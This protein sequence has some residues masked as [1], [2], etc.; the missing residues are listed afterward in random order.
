MIDAG[1][2]NQP[3]SWQEGRWHV[4]L[5]NELLICGDSVTSANQHW[6][7]RVLWKNTGEAFPLCRRNNICL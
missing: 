3:M 2:L 6:K 4:F 7:I 5:G 1:C